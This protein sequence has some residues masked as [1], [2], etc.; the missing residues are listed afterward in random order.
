MVYK[1]SMNMIRKLNV[2][3]LYGMLAWFQKQDGEWKKAFS[4][5]FFG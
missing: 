3:Y 2:Y 5:P 1:Y 4:L